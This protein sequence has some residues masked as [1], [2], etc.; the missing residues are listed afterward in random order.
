ME[1][2]KEIV[3]RYNDCINQGDVKGLMGWIT[4][5]Y[6]FVDSGGNEFAG[7]ETAQNI[8]ASFF[9]MFP[10]YRNHFE[11]YI[12]NDHC[13][14]I[15]GHSTCSDKRLSGKAIWKAGIQHDKI[16]LWQVFEYSP[17]LWESV[18]SGQI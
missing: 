8:W 14:W 4:P 5:D 1:S 18:Q 9:G 16:D 17:E 2:L 7:A 13:I 12:P 15:R 10:D 11:E 3:N 6:V